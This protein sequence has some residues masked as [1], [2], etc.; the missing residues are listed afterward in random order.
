MRIVDS[1]ADVSIS[2]LESKLLTILQVR[3]AANQITKIPLNKKGSGG[4]PFVTKNSCILLVSNSSIF[5]CNFE[6]F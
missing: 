4:K 3:N 5:F 1:K 6:R 2:R